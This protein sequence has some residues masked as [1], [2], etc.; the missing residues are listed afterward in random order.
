M[1]LHIPPIRIP[2]PITALLART[3]RDAGR[4]LRQRGRER[5]PRPD[6]GTVLVEDDGDGDEGEGDEAEEGA[7]PVDAEGVEHVRAEEGEDGAADGAEEGVGCDG[8]GGAV[9]YKNVLVRGWVWVW[10]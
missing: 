5:R 2:I 8:G 1:L 4:I 7:G 9:C 6:A 3:R 10:V